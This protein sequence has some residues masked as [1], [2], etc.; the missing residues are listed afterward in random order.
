MPLDIVPTKMLLLT[1][2]MAMSVVGDDA[3]VGG[4]TVVVQNVCEEPLNTGSNRARIRK[5]MWKDFAR[6]GSES[7]KD[8]NYSVRVAI[9][10]PQEAPAW[11]VSTVHPGGRLRFPPIL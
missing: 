9:P 11:L 4:K 3:V 1:G 2:E 7:R 8:L 6:K 10:N 5:C